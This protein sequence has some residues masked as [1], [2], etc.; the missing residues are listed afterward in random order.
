MVKHGTPIITMDHRPPVSPLHRN[1][2]V[3]AIF[4]LA[5]VNPPNRSA[6]ELKLY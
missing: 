6:S 3:V 4:L 1:S 5:F 2:I